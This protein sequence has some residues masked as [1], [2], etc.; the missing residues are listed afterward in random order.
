MLLL[1]ILKKI[2]F[3]YKLIIIGL[4]QYIDFN[5]ITEIRNYVLRC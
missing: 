2:I 4:Q 5:F 1:F 3:F